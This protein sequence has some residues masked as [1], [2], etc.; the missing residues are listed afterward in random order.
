MIKGMH[1]L[2]YSSEPEACRAFLRDKLG[3]RS[4]DAG[5]GWLIFQIPEADLGVHP[6][7][8]EHGGT[9]GRH[10]ISFYCEDLAATVAELKSRGVEFVDEISDQGFGLVTYFRLPGG[11]TAQLYSPHY[12]LDFE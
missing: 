8:P 7:V 4:A 1:G 9:P 2:F 3:F 12:R 10:E 6:P 11:L 5:G